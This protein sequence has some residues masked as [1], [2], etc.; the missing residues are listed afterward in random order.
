MFGKKKD[1]IKDEDIYSVS[2]NVEDI[3][4]SNTDS[5]SEGSND[6]V[7]KSEDKSLKAKVD[8][9]DGLIKPKDLKS[10]D[11]LKAKKEKY[12][13]GLKVKESKV[14]ET[15]GLKVKGA[16]VSDADGIDLKSL[17]KN[18]LREY[19]RTGKIN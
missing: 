9:T 8:E 6:L 1:K 19:R 10:A 14:L 3:F 13:D 18:Q 17:S 11:G 4:I 7:D 15:D 5:E 12:S 16:K 2:K